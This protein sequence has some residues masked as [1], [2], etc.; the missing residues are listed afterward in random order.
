MSSV[1][2]KDFYDEK[3][4]L[5][6]GATGTIGRSIIAKLMRLGNLKEILLLSRPKKDKTNDERLRKILS[7]FLFQEIEKLMKS[8]SAS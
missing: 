3:T 1:N 5:I 7:G 4:I 6:T 8:F 2:V